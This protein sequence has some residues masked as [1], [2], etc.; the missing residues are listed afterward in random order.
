M[1][2]FFLYIVKRFKDDYYTLVGHSDNPNIEDI[3]NLLLDNRNHCFVKEIVSG[4]YITEYEYNDISK[5]YSV[6]DVGNIDFQHI[7]NENLDFSFVKRVIEKN[8]NNKYVEDLKYN[9]DRPALECFPIDNTTMV[10]YLKVYIENLLKPLFKS[11]TRF[12]FTFFNIN[13]IRDLRILTG[14]LY[15]FTIKLTIL[16]DNKFFSYNYT[17]SNVN[18]SYNET[19]IELNVDNDIFQGDEYT[20][21]N[22][23]IDNSYFENPKNFLTGTNYDQNNLFIDQ[24]PQSDNKTDIEFQP[25]YYSNTDKIELFKLIVHELNKYHLLRALQFR[26]IID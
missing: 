17:I 12:K 21:H 6:Y 3:S 23:Y 20:E 1:T 8:L 22:P 7:D 14:F 9:L 2:L 11:D 19:T 5:T 26:D 25:S 16:K 4:K 13:V 24:H 10:Y 18:N 15:A